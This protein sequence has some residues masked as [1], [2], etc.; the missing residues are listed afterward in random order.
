[1]ENF[2]LDEQQRLERATKRVKKISGF[3]R[4]LLVYLLVNG[5]FLA[6][7]YFQL[8]PEES[9]LNYGNF[10]MAIWWGLGLAFH[11]LGVFGTSL[12]LGHGWEERKIRQI[13]EKEKG[14]KWE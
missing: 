8:K 6:L 7:K 9:F 12:F 3:Y 1:M 14:N 13:M 5:F 4:H 11:G 10:S 2:N